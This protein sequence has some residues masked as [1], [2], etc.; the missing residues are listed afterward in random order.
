MNVG[1]FIP[2]YKE[3]EQLEPLLQVLLADPYMNK[4]IIVCVDE[5][6]EKTEVIITELEIDTV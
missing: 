2:V 4:E 6:T 3:S 5:P 1:V